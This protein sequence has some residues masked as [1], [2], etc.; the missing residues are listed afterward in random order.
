VANLT[1]GEWDGKSN[2]LIGA[3]FQPHEAE[4]RIV[5][6]GGVLLRNNSYSQ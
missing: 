1:Q 3:E 2:L 6:S 4:P 5:K